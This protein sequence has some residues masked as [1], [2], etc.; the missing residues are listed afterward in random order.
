MDT[1]KQT[2]AEFLFPF[3]D[4]KKSSVGI[5]SELIMSACSFVLRKYT[6]IVICGV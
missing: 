4:V 1:T 5:L 6:R 2:L 3:F